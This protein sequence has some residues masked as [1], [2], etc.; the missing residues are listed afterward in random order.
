VV[1]ILCGGPVFHGSG[2]LSVRDLDK[3]GPLS[4]L[5]CDLKSGKWPLLKIFEAK[6]KTD[7]LKK[8]LKRH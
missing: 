2:W 3:D 7:I 6:D 4:A 8:K 5:A 1:R